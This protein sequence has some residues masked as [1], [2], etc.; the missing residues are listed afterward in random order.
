MTSNDHIY[1]FIGG[2][3]H[4]KYCHVN[5]VYN[6]G[7]IITLPR[8]TQRSAKGISRWEQP[9]ELDKIIT[10]IMVDGEFVIHHK[11]RKSNG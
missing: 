4:N 3:R 5:K 7:D 9:G 11:E 1:K 2:K 6:N 10:Y 8:H